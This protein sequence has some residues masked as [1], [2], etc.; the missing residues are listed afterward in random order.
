MSLLERLKVEKR[1]RAAYMADWV[2][3]D[4]GTYAEFLLSWVSQRTTT[5]STYRLSVVPEDL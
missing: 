5:G 4:G 2:K 1:P 3:G